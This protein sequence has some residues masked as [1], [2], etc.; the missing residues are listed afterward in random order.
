MG[1]GRQQNVTSNPP[2]A[3]APTFATSAISSTGSPWV[4]SG[5]SGERVGSAKRTPTTARSGPRTNSGAA[6]SGLAP[7]VKALFVSS[8]SGTTSSGSTTTRSS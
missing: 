4:T 2:A 1:T 5:E 3:S 7:V 6:C 8:S